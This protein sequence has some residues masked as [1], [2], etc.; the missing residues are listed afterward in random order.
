MG[1]GIRR[2]L[3]AVLAGSVLLSGALTASVLGGVP[4]ASAASSK[5]FK[6]PMP[7]IT[8]IPVQVIQTSDGP[9]SY[10]SD[11]SGP[12]LVMIMGFGGSQDVW[13]PDLVNALAEHHQ[14]ITF[15]NAGIG[16]TAMP[17][18]TLTIS[19]MADQTAALI[20][21]L[22]LGQPAVLGW[23]MGGMIAQALAIL[24]PGDLSRLVLCATFAGDGTAIPVP[25][26]NL[27]A[28]VNALS[29]GNPSAVIP[30]LFPPD[31]LAIQGPA[32]IAAI[33]SYPNLY[34]ASTAVEDDQIAAV[35]SWS[36]GTDPGGHGAVTVPTLIGG[37]AD[38]VLTLPV[39][40]KKMKKSIPG[41]RVHIY[42]DAGHG[43]VIQDA[44]SWSTRV[45]RF[46]AQ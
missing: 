27:T 20:E 14:V 6:P 38:D 19:A 3:G 34:L 33:S 23:S 35:D 2:R 11:G 32:Y 24:H 8:T 21:A 4:V 1:T 37:G 9:V 40:V 18:G 30:L 46:L 42:P 13:P 44:S 16:Q 28:L 22:N 17:P 15:D 31:Q 5:H 26:A 45:N 39:N 7:S 29:S 41:A 36:A 43:F 12:P 25:A 10:R